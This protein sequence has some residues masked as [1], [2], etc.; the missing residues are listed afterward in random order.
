MEICSS[1]GWHWRPIQ[2]SERITWKSVADD[3]VVMGRWDEQ[4]QER[5]A[6]TTAD[7][8]WKEFIQ[9]LWYRLFHPLRR[10]QR[11]RASWAQI[12]VA[13]GIKD[14]E[15]LTFHRV[16][17]ESIPP[18][19][20][21]PIQ[22]VKVR[23]LGF[24]AFIMGFHTVRLDIP[25]RDF[26]AYSRFGT[27]TPD[28]DSMG[29]VLR[30][31]GDILA[32]HELISR[33]SAV[34]VFRAADLVLGMLSFGKYRVLDAFQPLASLAQAICENTPSSLYQQQEREAIKASGMGYSTGPVYLEA[35][36]MRGYLMK[37][38][39]KLSLRERKDM[40]DNVPERQLRDFV[41][42]RP[43]DNTH[44]SGLFEGCAARWQSKTGSKMPTIYV[45]AT[46][47]NIHAVVC[48]FP[49]R[50]LL[51][52]F[53]P[54][55][56]RRAQFLLSKSPRC[57]VVSSKLSRAMT[58]GGLL[59]AR[60]TSDY[61]MSFSTGASDVGTYGWGITR[62]YDIFKAMPEEV[63]RDLVPD[64]GVWEVNALLIPE[65]ARLLMDFNIDAWA[66]SIVEANQTLLISF[67]AIN[68]LWI[69]IIVLDIAIQFF[70]HGHW[71]FE[72]V[73][74]PKD[75]IAKKDFIKLL[76]SSK[77]AREEAP[78][79]QYDPFYNETWGR[80]EAFV[81]QGIVR[82]WRQPGLRETEEELA[83]DEA[84]NHGQFAGDDDDLGDTPDWKK[85]GLDLRDWDLGEELIKDK[86]IQ[87]E[88][89]GASRGRRN[90]D[91]MCR[92]LADLLEL[93]AVFVFAFLLLHPDSSDIYDSTRKED[94]IEM[95]IE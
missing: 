73:E 91:A 81:V 5:V 90:R 20:D 28:S 65:T 41:F 62:M 85:L 79:P 66:S 75:Q 34:W 84:R 48:G 3:L 31:D 45:A 12:V 19:H 51:L 53:V 13:L 33:C 72:P 9:F 76:R 74:D 54:W 46:F 47:T 59:F 71:G 37:G 69:Q 93:R 86:A 24:L 35:M 44:L 64:E 22:R 80:K 16:D 6:V 63:Q 8:N 70:L 88:D 52:P 30:F 67:K 60:E 23:H 77:R 58:S 83:I 1:R 2:S 94:D 82:A 55:V 92:R 78:K 32:I 36:L 21:T 68:C 87:F 61:L 49:S 43:A 11:P 4:T 15:D 17:A 26:Q 14:T 40:M 29:R 57:T 89:D 27:I 42:Q 39:G 10:I 38:I 7:L 95:P 56:R 50:S 25:G 18:N